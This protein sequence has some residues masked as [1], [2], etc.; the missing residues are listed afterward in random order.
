MASQGGKRQVVEWPQPWAEWLTPEM[1]LDG[2]RERIERVAVQEANYLAG[3]PYVQAVA[4]V[5]GTGRGD[6]WPLSDIDLLV[7]ADGWQGQD[8]ESLLR[9]VEKEQ[10]A[11]LHAARIPNEI[12]VANWIIGSRE[13]REMAAGDDDAFLADPQWLWGAAKYYGGR[14][15]IDPDGYLAEVLERHT[16]LL[17]D[18]RFVAME[19][20]AIEAGPGRRLQ[21]A[22]EHLGRKDWGSA[23][24]ETLR[25]THDLTAGLYSAWRRVPQ[26]IMRYVTRLLRAANEVG[27]TG[28]AELFLTAARL[29]PEDTWRRFAQAPDRGRWE[30]DRALAIRRGAGEDVDCLGAT[31]DLLQ[32][33]SI[34]DAWRKKAPADEY[35]EWSGV[36]RDERTARTQFDAAWEIMSRLRAAK[37]DLAR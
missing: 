37:D 3:L 26:S 24:L 6:P 16:R 32:A 18:D 9:A 13:A 29:W 31:R 8:A 22:R 23:S 21:D 15:L 28:T 19:L 30:R 7:V 35:P 17:F 4:A 1:A 2:W 36:A 33:V 27:D 14:A 34:L 20:A 12:E 10:N 5:G 25:A 11:Q